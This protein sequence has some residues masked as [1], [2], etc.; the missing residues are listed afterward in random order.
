LPIIELQ[1][2]T[3]MLP[4]YYR[5]EKSMVLQNK[6]KHWISL[7]NFTA[8]GDCTTYKE[9]TM[10]SGQIHPLFLNPRYNHGN[11]SDH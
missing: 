5:E 1:T 6:H 2:Q 4:I 7:H 10:S 9:E 11:V 3:V 8:I